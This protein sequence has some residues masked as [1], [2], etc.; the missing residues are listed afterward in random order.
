LDMKMMSKLPKRVLDDLFE[1]NWKEIYNSNYIINF[2]N[3]R[4]LVS[5]RCVAVLKQVIVNNS[6]S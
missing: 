3:L 2:R 5:K 4:K 6:L 1:E